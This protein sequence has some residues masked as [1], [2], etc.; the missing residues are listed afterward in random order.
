MS[1]T[2]IDY[3]GDIFKQVESIYVVNKFSNPITCMAHDINEDGAVTVL[4][5]NYQDPEFY[6]QKYYP[7][8]NQLEYKI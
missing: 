7:V 8:F 5:A 2:E 1:S 6:Y 3:F 4:T